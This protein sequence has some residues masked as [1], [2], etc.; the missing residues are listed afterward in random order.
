LSSGLDLVPN[1]FASVSDTFARNNNGRSATDLIAAQGAMIDRYRSAGMQLRAA[2][3]FTAFGCPYE[4][5]V[6]PERCV[7]VL[8]DLL[9]VCKEHGEMPDVVYLCDTVGAANPLAVRRALDLARS[10]WPEQEFALHLHDTRGMGLSN[11]LAALQC[12]VKRFDTSI[13]GLGGCPFSGS[14]AAAGNV[15]T[16]DVAL[17]CEEMGIST[18]LNLDRL[19]EAACLAEEI[20]GHPLPGKFMKAGRIRRTSTH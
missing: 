15:C 4:G 16:E 14:K 7:E 11:V 3:I 13:A 8:G 20:V 19:A 9:E 18:G 12:G 6:A 5:I 10:R 2:H 1:V 17:M